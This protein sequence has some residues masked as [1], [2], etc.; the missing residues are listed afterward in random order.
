MIGQI[1]HRAGGKVFHVTLPSFFTEDKGSFASAL[2]EDNSIL[3]NIIDDMCRDCHRIFDISGYMKYDRQVKVREV[4]PY[5]ALPG[6][7]L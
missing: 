2:L 6:N 7:I 5:M 1:G 3:Y 4:K